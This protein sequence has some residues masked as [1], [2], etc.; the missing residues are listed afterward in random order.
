MDIPSHLKSLQ[1]LELAMRKGSFVDAGE[2]L[3][4]TPAAVGQRVKALEDYLGIRLVER[5]RAG[6][7]ATPEL[8]RALPF[9]AR[10]FAELALASQE[11]DLQR[12]SELQ[13]AAL[14]DFAELWLE[15]RLPAFREAHPNVRICVN[16]RGDAPLRLGRVDC[17]IA[18]ASPDSAAANTDVLFRDLVV[19]LGSPVNWARLRTQQ[20]VDSLEGFPLLHVDFY[21]DDPAG[22]SWPAWFRRTGLQRTAPE[23]GIRFQRIDAAIAAVAADAG[24]AL[25]GLALLPAGDAAQ[26]MSSSFAPPMGTW[27]DWAFTARFR[28]D[29]QSRPITSRFR[30]WLR[31]EAEQTRARLQRLAGA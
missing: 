21:K 2:A 27:T 9:L 30:A 26:F 8:Q 28:Q 7:R 6:L 18:F 10:G 15:P 29:W 1:A 20:Q 25:C 19:P 24:I 3:G 22:I 12:G 13:I 4:I 14:P 23:R 11:L 5:G 17:E 16:G 31:A